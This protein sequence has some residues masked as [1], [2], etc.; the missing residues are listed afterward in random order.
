LDHQSGARQD[1]YPTGTLLHTDAYR[2][3]NLIAQSY[4]NVMYAGVTGLVLP[5][6]FQPLTH[7]NAVIGMIGQRQG[8]TILIINGPVN[9]ADTV[10]MYAYGNPVKITAGG[11]YSKCFVDQATALA[12]PLETALKSL[13]PD[14]IT[15]LGHDAG[16]AVA[17]VMPFLDYAHMAPTF[18]GLLREGAYKIISFG[19]PE[20]GD[21]A[22]NTMAH[23]ALAGKISAYIFLMDQIAPFSTQTTQLVDVYCN[24]ILITEDQYAE[25]VYPYYHSIGG[26]VQNLSPFK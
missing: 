17:K 15:I 8:E 2:Y 1:I 16:G 24:R 20:G 18:A 25:N 11:F 10:A 7:N 13:A 6:D 4:Q 22:F 12:A 23:G 14:A 9:F 26:Y 21:D 3:A 19:A 5:T